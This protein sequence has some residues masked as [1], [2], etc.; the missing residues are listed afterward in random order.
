MLV[1]AKTYAA[2]PVVLNEV[3]VHP[4]AGGKEWVEFYV[5]DA[6]ELKSYWIDDD[7]DFANDIGSAKKSLDTVLQG[8]TSQHYFIELSASMFNNSGD[9]IV[10]FKFDGT[11]V[12]QLSYSDG[13]GYDVTMGRTPDVNGTF[14]YLSTTTRG[15]PNSGPRPTVTPTPQPTETPT[16]QPVATKEPI[17]TTRASNTAAP[18]VRATRIPSLTLP[19]ASPTL[20]AASA[21]AKA[22]IATSGAYPTAILGMNTTAAP[23]RIPLPS[24]PVKVKSASN[25]P[26]VATLFGAAFMIACA[27]LLIVKKMR[28]VS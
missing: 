21:S 6:S 1:P 16:K 2:S 18:T 4:S 17:A 12:D 27:I 23:T 5:T 7:T 20:R 11:M 10:L 19:K 3:L 25:T 24:I 28:K 26:A 22:K 13:P 8:N 9:T 14:H 15:S